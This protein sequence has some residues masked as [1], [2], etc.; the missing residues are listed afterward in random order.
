MKY[1]PQFVY[2]NLLA[3]ILFLT[4]S[5]VLVSVLYNELF[6]FYNLFWISP[7]MS[8]HR[9]RREGVN[10]LRLQTASYVR[11][12]TTT[13]PAFICYYAYVCILAEMLLK[14]VVRI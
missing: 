10:S 7:C 11:T 9:L 14:Y 8:V 6:K 2:Y 4:S 3:H 5:Y 12:T 13:T 1:I